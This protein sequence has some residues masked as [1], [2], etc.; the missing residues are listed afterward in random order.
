MNCLHEEGL[1]RESNV[2]RYFQRKAVGTGTSCPGHREAERLNHPEIS[3]YKKLLHF[4]EGMN[5]GG[6]KTTVAGT[7]W[8]LQK[9]GLPG[10]KGSQRE[11]AAIAGESTKAERKRMFWPF[12]FSLL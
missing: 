12:F 11:R 7:Q 5:N 10:R 9:E 1:I 2:S 3:H 6:A 8:T 4:Q